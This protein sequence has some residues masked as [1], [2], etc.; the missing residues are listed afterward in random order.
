MKVP[1]L[2]IGLCLSL[3]TDSLKLR[4]V[5]PYWVDSA[6]SILEMDEESRA[7][8]PMRTESFM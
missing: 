2:F 6:V 5:N 4:N 7:L 1:T 3:E 8:Y